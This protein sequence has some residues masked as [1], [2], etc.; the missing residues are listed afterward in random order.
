MCEGRKTLFAGDILV[1]AEHPDASVVMVH[2][3]RDH[4]RVGSI[5]LSVDDE[6]LLITTYGSQGSVVLEVEN[7]NPAIR[8]KNEG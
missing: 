3:L 2:K 6:G 4:R 1:E 7:G 5:M 8:I